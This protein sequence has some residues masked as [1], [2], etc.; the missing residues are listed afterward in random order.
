MHVTC[1]C[2]T[3]DEVRC[4]QLSFFSNVSCLALGGNYLEVTNYKTVNVLLDA[5]IHILVIVSCKML[6]FRGL[7]HYY[8]I[9][10]IIAKFLYVLKAVYG[11][12]DNRGGLSN[13]GTE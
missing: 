4:H 11:A 12:R 3:V 13:F 8:Y 5:I 10:M 2:V 9:Y 6:R 1:K 7:H